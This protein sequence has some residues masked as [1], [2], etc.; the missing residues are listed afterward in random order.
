MDILGQ[1][2]MNIMTRLWNNELYKVKQGDKFEDSL[3]SNQA[4]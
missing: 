3:A 2:N 1:G 4:K